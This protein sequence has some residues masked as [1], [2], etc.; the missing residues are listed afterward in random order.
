MRAFEVIGSVLTFALSVSFAAPHQA[1]AA[2]SDG[3][4]V[5]VMPYVWAPKVRGTT[6]LGQLSVPVEVTPSD[7]VDG[8][9]IGGMGALKIE[10]G[11]VFAYI[12]AI[13]VDYDNRNFRPFFSQPVKAKIRFGEAGVGIIR[14][15]K[16][17]P[18]SVLRVSPHIGI[19]YLK[20]DTAVGGNIL[21]VS[22]GGEWINPA[23]GVMVDFPI[24]KR[25][26]VN[27]QFNGAGFGLTDT[28]YLNASTRLDY[29]L[30]QRL[31]VGVGYRFARANFQN[32]QALAL[33][34]TGGGPMFALQYRFRIG[35]NR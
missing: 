14:T 11:R 12:D 30:S 23:A 15:V 27:G 28:N 1:Q 31:S 10:R 32:P 18:K 33:D 17:G 8:L 35:S 9:K 26:T 21:A 19:Q 24:S 6:A 2:P 22:T 34:L 16:R 13:V 25:F 20:I 29:R 3:T 5:T 4:I 7:F